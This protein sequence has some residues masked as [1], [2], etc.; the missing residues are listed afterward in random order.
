MTLMNILS[1]TQGGAL[2]ADAGEAAGLPP[3][4]AER[5]MAALC[6]VIAH[7]LKAKSAEDPEMFETLLDLLEDNTATEASLTDAEAVEDGQAI[8]A[9]IY[10][11]LNAALAELR[12]SAD[13]ADISKL[14][15]ISATSVLAALASARKPVP[16]TG[17]MPAASSGGI[18]GSI[19]GSIVTAFVGAIIQGLFRKPRAAPAA[20]RATY[21]T[22]RRKKAA[23]TTRR[24]AK[25]SIE[26]IFGSIL[27]R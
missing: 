18:I 9:D 7:K 23:T 27:K 22:A 8:L 13:G 4:E 3:A 10:G 5:V 16:L 14:A 21:T 12:K 25:P 15:P 20:K 2:Y 17:A 11:S 26:D 24:R 6:P 19:I 1:Q